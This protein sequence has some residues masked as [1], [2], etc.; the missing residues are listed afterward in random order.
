MNQLKLAESI[1]REVNK[2]WQS[3]EML[4]KV[5]PTTAELLKYWFGEEYCDVREKNF[6][7]G[8]KQA[9][10]NS[11]Y[12]HEVAKINSVFDLQEKFCKENL[13]FE[14]E[15]ENLTQ[16]KYC[17]PKY[18]IKMATGTGKTWVMHA[19]ILWQILNHKRKAQEGRF[20][21]NFLLIA[22][23]KIVYNRL[24]DAFKGK[25]N[26]KSG[27]RDFDTN[28]FK[29]N[30]ELFIPYSYR[31]E[32]YSFLQNNVKDR[33]NID[34]IN[35]GGLIAITNWHIFIDRQ[36]E[37]IS[38]QDTEDARAI[39]KDLLPAKP[40]TSAGNSLEVLDNSYL[41]GK[42]LE[43]LS[44]LDSLMIINDE[45]HHLHDS[46]T[47]EKDVVWQQGIDYVLQNKTKG[48]LQIDFSA[49]PYTTIGS[50][51]N[52]K[53]AYFPHIITDFD[54]KTAM[55]Q[56]LVKLINLVRREELTDV[57]LSYKAIRD[58]NNDVV[59]LSEGQRIM[60]SAGL[61]KLDILDE[62]FKELA[63]EK[64][65]YKQPKMLV[66]CEDTKVSPFVVDFLYSKGLSKEEVMQIDS[67]KEGEVSDREW[68]EIKGK[69]FNMDNLKKPRVIVSVLM[70]REGFD[71]NNICVIVPLRT[72]DSAI[73]LEQT[74]GRGLR[75]MFR[76]KEFEQTKEENRN[77]L[78]SH[79][80][81][82][83]MIDMLSIVEH[84]NFIQYY[85]DLLKE[86]FAT[87]QDN[88]GKGNVK[89]NLMSISLKEEYE[90]YDLYFPQ[91]LRSEQEELQPL[92]IDIN[93]LHCFDLYPLE[94]LQKQ[95]AKK[96]RGF[97][98]Y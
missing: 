3:G 61:T 50:G 88:E 85:N 18:C 65:N 59:G 76:G 30:E 38:E 63:T 22:P 27:E 29:L 53:K 5:T 66:M 81:P 87:I 82:N 44:N 84:P 17:F 54:S 71:V 16:E 49:T 9:I 35:S 58:E 8:Q 74:I 20:T 21:N 55:R 62:A 95:F 40:G 11:I 48:K 67:T 24:L 19:L 79:K 94:Y 39:I 34:T 60:L 98:I 52:K 31:D 26:I 80:E 68:D 12:L 28:D 90:E 97:Q 1:N 36:Q 15:R 23:G 70:L 47:K 42:S 2:L 4:S 64:D 13:L 41:R 96:R 57:E 83:S 72:T 86:G 6:H 37:D 93:D 56:G 32:V 51:K 69:L 10:L 91:I 45:A 7:I 46:N 43:Y 14:Q 25:T 75:L 78:F 77:L 92:N 89:G 33:D 73:L